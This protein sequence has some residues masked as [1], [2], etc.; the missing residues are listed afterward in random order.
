M[1]PRKTAESLGF[2]SRQNTDETG[3]RLTIAPIFW[4][5]SQGVDTDAAA[6]VG[7]K[8]EKAATDWTILPCPFLDGANKSR[9][10]ARSDVVA[11]WVAGWSALLLYGVFLLDFELG[12]WGASLPYS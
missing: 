11:E 5:G 1:T 9:V 7:Q 12:R 8:I 10:D 2:S 6:W 3:R 4:P